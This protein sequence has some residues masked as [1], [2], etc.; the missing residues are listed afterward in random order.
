[1]KN[2]SSLPILNGRKSRVC[3]E[4]TV[5]GCTSNTVIYYDDILYCF[6]VSSF[7]ILLHSWTA[8]CW[9]LH[10]HGL[11]QDKLLNNFPAWQELTFFFR[12]YLCRSGLLFLHRKVLDP[13][14][15][16]IICIFILRWFQTFNCS[17]KWIKSSAMLTNASKHGIND[18]KTIHNIAFCVA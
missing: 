11:L 13:Y 6:F 10:V 1:M 4:W 8:N 7:H 18:L 17:R 5:A 14:F 16:S 9:R 12:I 15:L 2:G 3:L